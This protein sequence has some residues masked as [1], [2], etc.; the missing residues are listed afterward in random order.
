MIFAEKEAEKAAEISPGDEADANREPVLNA[1]DA[2]SSTVTI[3]M[4]NRDVFPGRH[5]LAGHA[6]PRSGGSTHCDVSPHH[7]WSASE[8]SV[9]CDA[10]PQP[11]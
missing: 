11:P 10:P 7:V 8:Q 5:G 3:E 1:E 6:M 4:S 2:N 9:I